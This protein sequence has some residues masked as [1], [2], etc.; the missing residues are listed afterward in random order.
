MPVAMD[1]IVL[2]VLNA[3]PAALVTD[4][5]AAWHTTAVADCG[6]LDARLELNLLPLSIAPVS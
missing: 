6:L 2:A 4:C 3:P 5:I 1:L